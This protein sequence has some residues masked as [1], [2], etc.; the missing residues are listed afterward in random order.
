MNFNILSFLKVGSKGKRAEKTELEEKH[1]EREN[2]INQM[3]A[4]KS[5]SSFKVRDRAKV[6]DYD[7]DVEIIFIQKKTKPNSAK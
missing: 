6:W 4:K 7:P 3:E 5:V 2:A 1:G